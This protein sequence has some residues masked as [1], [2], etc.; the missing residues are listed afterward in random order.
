MVILLCCYYKIKK[1]RGDIMGDKFDPLLAAISIAAVL[2]EKPKNKR[3]KTPLELLETLTIE[4]IMDM[5]EED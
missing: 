3:K 1:E 5:H 2:K 4:E